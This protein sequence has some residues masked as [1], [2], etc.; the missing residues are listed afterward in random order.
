MNYENGGRYIKLTWSTDRN[1]FE[2]I[3]MD[4]NNNA[5]TF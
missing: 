3:Y 5:G 4:S 2:G 1:Q